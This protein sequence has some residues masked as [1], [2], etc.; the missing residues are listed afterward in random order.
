MSLVWVAAGLGEEL[1]VNP[2]FLSD[3]SFLVTLG[4]LNVRRTNGV[5]AR[6]DAAG[7]RLLLRK[8]DTQMWARS[9]WDRLEEGSAWMRDL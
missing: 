5:D 7:A 2:E 3:L 9:L 8:R 1:Q 4:L 6:T